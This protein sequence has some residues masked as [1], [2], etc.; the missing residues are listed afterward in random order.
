M[1]RLLQ[2]LNDLGQYAF[3]ARGA[4][5]DLGA[6]P[7]L[8]AWRN[9]ADEARAAYAEWSSRRDR[10]SYFVYRA[11]ADRTDAAQESLAAR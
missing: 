9:A 10:D 7:E 4:E 5:P 11:C 8:E 1:K 2:D 6:P 3:V